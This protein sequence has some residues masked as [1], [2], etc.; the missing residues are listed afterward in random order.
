M[1]QNKKL[2]QVRSRTLYAVFEG[3]LLNVKADSTLWFYKWKGVLIAGQEANFYEVSVNYFL[4]FQVYKGAKLV[5]TPANWRESSQ[6]MLK[7]EICEYKKMKW[8][9]LVAKAVLEEGIG[10]CYGKC[11]D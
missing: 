1:A 3:K 6:N 9:S 5:Q 8:V 7:F 11:W 2:I 4:I 10:Q